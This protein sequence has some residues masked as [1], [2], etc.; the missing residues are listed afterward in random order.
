M[1]FEWNCW[2]AAVS[3][4][5]CRPRADPLALP[6]GVTHMSEIELKFLLDEASAKVLLSRLKALKL[7]T[8]PPTRK[9]LRS[10][11]LDTPDHALRKAEIALRLRRDGRRWV[12]TVKARV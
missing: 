7:A 6:R 4:G 5:P 9:T 10:I 1:I 8:R 3:D 12:Q 2:Q 11:Y